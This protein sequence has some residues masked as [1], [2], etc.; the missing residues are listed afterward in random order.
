[1]ERRKEFESNLKKS[2]NQFSEED[3][4]YIKSFLADLK[5]RNN[6]IKDDGLPEDS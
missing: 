5:K 2:E 6:I 1:M 4:H 3:Q